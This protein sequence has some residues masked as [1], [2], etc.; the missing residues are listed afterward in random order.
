MFYN[1]LPI[2]LLKIIAVFCGLAEYGSMWTAWAWRGGTSPKNTGVKSVSPGGWTKPG[3][4]SCSFLKEPNS[5]TV[6]TSVTGEPALPPR[7]PKV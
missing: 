6:R 5:T 7:R 3:P 4:G 2:M 1:N